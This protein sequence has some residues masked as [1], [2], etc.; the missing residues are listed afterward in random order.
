MA[1]TGNDGGIIMNRLKTVCTLLLMCFVVFCPACGINSDKNEK[2]EQGLPLNPEGIESEEMTPIKVLISDDQ[3]GFV[4]EYLEPADV[5]KYYEKKFTYDEIPDDL[6]QTFASSVSSEELQI[7]ESA[8]IDAPSK[9]LRGAEAHLYV[10][11]RALQNTENTDIEITSAKFVPYTFDE[12]FTTMEEI[13]GCDGYAL[14]ITD[15]SGNI[16]LVWDGCGYE[17][18]ICNGEKIYRRYHVI[19]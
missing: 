19:F 16:Y 8:W 14:Q 7:V 11:L 12:I 18:V 6:L 17:E 9:E 1:I 2:T 13:F 15:A 4:T 5:E 3:D 10:L